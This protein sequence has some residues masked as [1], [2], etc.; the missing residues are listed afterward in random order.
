MDHLGRAGNSMLNS[1]PQELVG[2]LEALDRS[3]AVIEFKLDGSIITA[4]RNFL[5]AVGYD[6][7]E[8]QGRHHRMF[9]AD[10]ERASAAYKS[11]WEALNRGEFQS[12]EFRRLGK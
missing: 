10:E 9:V 2:K 1:R 4:N 12:G 3:Q 8:I 11:F 6:L 5:E 7:S